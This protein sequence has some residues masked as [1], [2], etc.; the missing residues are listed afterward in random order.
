MVVWQEASRRAS[1]PD[2]KIAGEGPAPDG[3]RKLGPVGK[4]CRAAGKLCLPN[5]GRDAFSRGVTA[6]NL[7]FSGP[8]VL[9]L[10]LAVQPWST[11]ASE[12]C[13]P[14][15]R[16]NC[17]RT[18]LPPKPGAAARRRPNEAFGRAATLGATAR[19]LSPSGPRHRS[20][21]SRHSASATSI[22]RGGG[23]P[24]TKL[25]VQMEMHAPGRTSRVAAKRPGAMIRPG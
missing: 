1:L 6:E 18:P 23:T 8:C 15:G 11:T 10:R 20:G 3:P 22:R 9:G 21:A 24:R 4:S 25:R 16:P 12:R 19:R 5:A 14:I 7:A 13:A 2:R 17:S